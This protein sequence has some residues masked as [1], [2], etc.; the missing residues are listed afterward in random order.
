MLQA[1][2]YTFEIKLQS[3]EWN[4]VGRYKHTP[5]FIDY[6]ENEG[7][8]HNE[9]NATND[10]AEGYRAFFGHFFGNFYLEIDIQS[11]NLIE[12]RRTF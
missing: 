9:S 3:R 2:T 11:T 5:E 4:E 12:E 6:V 10:D 1:Y 7:S 8:E